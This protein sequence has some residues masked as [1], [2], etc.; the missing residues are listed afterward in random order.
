MEA[1]FETS[2][3]ASLTIGGIPDVENREVDYDIEI[4]Y[5]LS[6][7]AQGDFN[8]K[9]TGLDQIPRKDWPPVLI[10]NIAFQIM[11]GAGLLM[12]G[13]GGLYFYFLWRKKETIGKSWFR[14]LVG[15]CMPLGFIAVEAGWTVT[16]VGRQPWIIYGIMKSKDALSPMPGLQYSFYMI[17]GLYLLLSAIVVWLMYR[18]IITL[19]GRYASA[20]TTED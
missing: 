12:M 7:L 19:S 1:L 5:L 4:P 8:A 18:Q 15:A 14:W 10:T 6:F 2:Q 13:V 17:T 11:V 9:V 3:P 16:E 20:N